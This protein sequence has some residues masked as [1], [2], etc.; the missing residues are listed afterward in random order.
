MFFAQAEVIL[1]LLRFGIDKIRPA[2]LY[3]NE[4]NLAGKDFRGID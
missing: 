4:L 2:G 3:Q 1:W